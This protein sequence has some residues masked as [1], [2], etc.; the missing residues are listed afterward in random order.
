MSVI[1]GN[2]IPFLDLVTPHVELEQELTKV[3]QQALRTA[4][5]IGGPMVEEFEKAFAVFCQTKHAVAVNSGTD[6]LRFALMAAGVRS[7]DVVVT[8][9]HTFIATTEA[10]SQAGALPE[11]VDI[12][13]IVVLVGDEDGGGTGH[14]LRPGQGARIDHEHSVVAAFEAHAGVAVFRQTH[15]IKLAAKRKRGSADLSRGARIC[16]RG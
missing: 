9:P 14:R 8:V 5:F 7:G 2:S 13:V 16:G 11:F 6:A 4:G 3:F 12:D 15:P 10:I 1:Q